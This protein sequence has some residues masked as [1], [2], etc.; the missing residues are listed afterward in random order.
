VLED[1]DDEPRS[2]HQC[3]KC[4]IDFPS[5]SSGF[6]LISSQYGWRCTRVRLATGAV[7]LTWYCP[8]CWRKHRPE[9]APPSR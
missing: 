8:P 7:Q 9:A 3:S 5:T 6:T 4:G 1:D 2:Q